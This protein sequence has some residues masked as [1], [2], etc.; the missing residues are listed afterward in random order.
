MYVHQVIFVCL[1]DTKY[2]VLIRS[3]MKIQDGILHLDKV[4]CPSLMISYHHAHH[5][6][7]HDT[8]QN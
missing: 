4:S 7:W 5:E 2:K 6:A 3:V 1:R 8:E